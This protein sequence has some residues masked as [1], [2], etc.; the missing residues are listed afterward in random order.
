MSLFSE[1]EE[2]LIE[3]LGHH[4]YREFY[5]KFRNKVKEILAESIEHRMDK[6]SLLEGTP[7]EADY[8]ITVKL[9]CVDRAEAECDM[10]QGVG[11]SINLHREGPICQSYK[12]TFS[13]EFLSDL[14]KSLTPSKP[15]KKLFPTYFNSEG[16]LLYKE[17]YLRSFTLEETLYILMHIENYTVA[18]SSGVT[19]SQAPSSRATKSG[20]VAAE[21]MVGQV[22]NEDLPSCL[23][24]AYGGEWGYCLGVDFSTKSIK[25]RPT[26]LGSDLGRARENIQNSVNGLLKSAEQMG[27]LCSLIDEQRGSIPFKKKLVKDILAKLKKERMT[28]LDHPTWSKAARALLRGK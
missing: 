19:P 9:Y 10:Y 27:K 17:C 16:F 14:L 28:L 25:L 8:V 5:N 3:Y 23:R 24:F 1:Q 15:R 11:L 18:D 26:Y 22:I 20:E 7:G 6:D 12:V 4:A 21:T 2:A 13:P